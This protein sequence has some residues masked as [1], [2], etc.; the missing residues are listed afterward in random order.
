[1]ADEQPPQTPPGGGP[2]AEDAGAQEGASLEG[3]EEQ[4]TASFGQPAGGNKPEAPKPKKQGGIKALLSRF[5]LYLLLFVLILI[6][7]VIVVVVAVMKGNSKPQSKVNDQTLTQ[8]SISQLAQS[9]V[10]VGDVKQT[11]SVQSNAVFAG[12]VLVRKDLQVAGKLEVGGSLSLTGITVS[13]DSV[14]DQMQVNK[15]LSVGG[16]GAIQGQLTVQKSLAVN[17]GGTFNGALSAPQLTVGSL[18]ISGDL[19]LTHHIEAGG[20]NPGRSNGNALGGGGTASVSGSDTAGSITINTGGG[21]ASGCMVTINFATKF[22]ATPHVV[23]TPVEAAA[24]GL[25]YYITRNTSGFSVC[26]ANAPPAGATFGF[27]YIVFD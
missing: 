6:I 3:D 26:T 9:D 10:T 17:G 14:F 25:Q 24:A 7:A 16:D 19:A 22:N 27:D 15:N 8:S 11:L 1:M 4:S 12:Q 23:I 5:S 20:V 21:P 13:G 18:Q 2:P